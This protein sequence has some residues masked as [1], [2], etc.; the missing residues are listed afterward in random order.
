[1]LAVQ[2]TVP[3]IP[4]QALQLV[5]SPDPSSIRAR[6]GRVWGR[7]YSSLAILSMFRKEVA[8]FK[9]TPSPPTVYRAQLITCQFG[10]VSK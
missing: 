1:M 5:S 8:L 6:L 9:V 3:Q 2:Q 7:D 10:L 4:Q